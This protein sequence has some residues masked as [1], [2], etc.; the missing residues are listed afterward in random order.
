MS[1][2]DGVQVGLTHPGMVLQLIA[3]ATGCQFVLL[4]TQHPP[5]QI[6][7]WRAEMPCRL[8]LFLHRGA[9][10]DRGKFLGVY[11]MD[12]IADAPRIKSR[13][14]T[15]HYNLSLPSSEKGFRSFRKKTWRGTALTP[16]WGEGGAH[17]Y[18]DWIE[19]CGRDIGDDSEWQALP[20]AAYEGGSLHRINAQSTV[21][22]GLVTQPAS[23]V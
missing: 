21:T 16:E 20:L 18:Q 7:Q 19:P 2:L 14:W 8:H 22:S 10:P 4:S 13:Q 12:K 17:L 23:G 5:I 3:F 11:P 6:P 9:G 1:G 15:P